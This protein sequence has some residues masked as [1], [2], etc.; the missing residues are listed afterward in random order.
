VS[1]LPHSE[2]SS[3]FVARVATLAGAARAELYGDIVRARAHVDEALLLAATHN[4]VEGRARLLAL[5]AWLRARIGD[6]GAAEDVKEALA[7]LDGLGEPRAVAECQLA[8]AILHA[9]AGRY[10]DA[11][12]PIRRVRLVAAA[13]GYRELDAAALNTL[14]FTLSD[15]GDHDQADAVLRAALREAE[16]AGAGS[17]RVLAEANLAQNH[18]RRV[19]S[20]RERGAEI[21]A[22]LFLDEALRLLAG[23]KA[24]AIPRGDV[25]G[26]AAALDNEAQVHNARGEPQKALACVAEA[27]EIYRWT[28]GGSGEVYA[29]CSEA[30]ALLLLG[31]A[32]G[33]ASSARSALAHAERSPA[34]Y[35]MARAYATLAAA[36]EAAGLLA[37][38]LAAFKRFHAL[39]EAAV[40]RC[41][42]NRA[43]VVLAQM[44]ADRSRAEVAR[45]RSRA[46]ELQSTIEGLRATAS[47]YARASREDSLTGLANRRA[48]EEQLEDRFA[49]EG[50]SR[51]FVVAL[52]DVDDFKRINDEH[53]HALGDVV[54][55]ELA[56]IVRGALR[57]RDPAARLGGDEL[58]VVL[59]GPGAR[60]ALE[61]LRRM[62]ADHPWSHFVEGLALTVSIGW[63]DTAA[64]ETATDALA[65]ADRQLYTAKR[66]GRNRVSP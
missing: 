19:R 56:T 66:A 6:E 20:A 28:G 12:E 55:R 40:R 29:R 44:E 46:A 31:D 47:A 11:F 32:R 42:V 7:T 58:V 23:V 51:R 33:A 24:H 26:L 36:S 10:E 5:R 35:G 22:P 50:A 60:A 9:T 39:G 57:Q 61:R 63:C 62:V 41:A 13:E 52:L 54:L 3:S 21:D 37:D 4:I 53:S 43:R 59:D 34:L 16:T 65:E 14:G 49:V 38:A 2:P 18:V 15:L 30:D 17:L 64:V 48:L 27:L 25:L 8:L 1:L 45:E